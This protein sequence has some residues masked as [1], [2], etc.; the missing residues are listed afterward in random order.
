MEKKLKNIIKYNF[1]ITIVY[2]LITFFLT[3]NTPL[4][5]YRVLAIGAYLAIF[6]GIHSIFLISLIIINFILKKN[7]DA[8]AFIFSQ[9]LILLIGVPSCFGYMAIQN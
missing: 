4:S 6:I 2:Y 5:Q 9:L 7:E 8:K 1:V 3:H